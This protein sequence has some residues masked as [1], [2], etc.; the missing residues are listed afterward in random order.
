MKCLNEG[1]IQAYI[2]GEVSHQDKVAIE[3]HLENCSKCADKFE[4]QTKISF[5]MKEAI[6]SLVDENE[7]EALSVKPKPGNVRKF[8]MRKITFIEIAASL[9]LMALFIFSYRQSQ[10]EQIPSIYYQLEWEV[11]ANRPITD[12]DFQITVW[13]AEG[14]IIKPIN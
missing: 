12:Q 1:L 6:N 7:I 13:E 10:K 5:E 4:E 14:D 11:D 2:D 8:S 9:L 3:S